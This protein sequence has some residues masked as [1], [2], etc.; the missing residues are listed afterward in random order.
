M[1]EYRNIGRKSCRDGDPP[2]LPAR[3]FPIIPPFQYSNIPTCPPEPWRRLDEVID[4]VFKRSNRIAKLLAFPVLLQSASTEDAC[5]AGA[6]SLADDAVV[7][8]QRVLRDIVQ[9][10][11]FVRE[12]PGLRLV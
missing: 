2:S 6:A 11:Q 1:V 8:R 3:V 7:A 12:R 4:K 9:D 10:A 5:G